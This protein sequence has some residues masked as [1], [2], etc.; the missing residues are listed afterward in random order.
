M[1][2]HFLSLADS[3]G[4]EIEA[5]VHLGITL[6]RGPQAAGYDPLPLRGRL[7]ALLF[8]K[9]SLR[10]RASFEAG[11]VKLGGQTMVLT[12]SE[13]GLGKR[14]APQD[15]ARVLSRYVDVIMVRTFEQTEVETIAR[16]SRVPVING[17]TDLL[18]P[19]QVLA[20]LLTISE[21]RGSLGGCVLA[22]VGDGNNVANSLVNAALRLPLV[23]RLGVPEGY[24]PNAQI[25]ARASAEGRGQV[26]L[27]HDPYEAVTGAEFV[28][29][30]VWASMGQEAEAAQ[31]RPVFM[32]FQVNKELLAHARDGAQVLHCLPAHRGEEITE[33]VL[34]GPRSLVYEQAEN[35]MWAQQAI[36]L[37]TLLE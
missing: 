22:Y 21:V 35:R 30:D 10:T 24:D 16:E 7:L 26:H 28:Y 23:V 31:R 27:L 19:C 5:L 11:M 18:H 8:R 4:A 33:D 13:V 14:E 17:L 36:L 15:V 29:T 9:P 25:L 20:D 34:D 37:E 32:P 6:K 1:A 2:K 12:Q 3:T